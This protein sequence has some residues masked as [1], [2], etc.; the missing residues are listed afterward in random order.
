[1][2]NLMYVPSEDNLGSLPGARD[3]RFDFVRR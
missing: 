1:M 2:I 3:D